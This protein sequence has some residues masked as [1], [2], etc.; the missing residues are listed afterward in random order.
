MR[1]F[2]TV[3]PA[4]D[5]DV[6]EELRFDDPGRALHSF[7]AKSAH[8]SQV[9]RPNRAMKCTTSQIELRSKRL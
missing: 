6:L 4:I 3:D 9:P 8:L 7:Y 1:R 5:P 2:Q